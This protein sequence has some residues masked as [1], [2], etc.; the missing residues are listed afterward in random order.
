MKRRLF[1]M[2]PDAAVARK[3][4]TELRAAGVEAR[5]MH[6][7]GRGSRLPADLPEATFLQ[8]TDFLPALEAGGVLGAIAGAAGGA[9]VWLFPPRGLMP[10]WIVILVGGV[11]GLVLGGWLAS[12]AGSSAPNSALRAFENSAEG[13]NVLLMIDLPEKRIDEI[14]ALVASHYP[15]ARWG[16]II[17][18]LPAFK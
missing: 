1:F 6:F 2:L 14:H 13:G 4:F 9:L 12:I 11:L 5:H 3:V 7:L 15:E 8:K 10:E 17:P 16:G 18:Q